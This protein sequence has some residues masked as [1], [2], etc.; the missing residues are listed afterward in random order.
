MPSLF[1]YPKLEICLDL[2]DHFGIFLISQLLQTGIH[3]KNAAPFILVFVLGNKVEVQVAAGITVCTVVD[4][5]GRESG[6][7]GLGSTVDIG[8]E[9]V[10]ILVADVHDLTDVI[11]VSNDAAAG[12]ALLLE[13]VQRAYAQVADIDAESSKGFAVYAV[14]AIGILHDNDL[15]IVGVMHWYGCPQRL[16]T[17]YTGLC[18]KKQWEGAGERITIKP[19]N[20]AVRG[21]L[22]TLWR[23]N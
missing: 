10:A 13:Q 23:S 2:F 18:I 17:Y 1:F 20:L 16:N 5:V 4:L 19:P 22:F 3:S 6:M 12:M 7:D 9:G 14:S 21:L 15:L 8:K 11:L